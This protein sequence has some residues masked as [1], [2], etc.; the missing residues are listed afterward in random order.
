MLGFLQ[1]VLMRTFASKVVSTKWCLTY[2]TAFLLTLGNAIAAPIAPTTIFASGGPGGATQYWDPSWTRFNF[3]KLILLMPLLI[4]LGLL[5][6][7]I[8]VKL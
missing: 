4:R 5:R 8:Q 6:I 7:L 1:R 3:A 2:L